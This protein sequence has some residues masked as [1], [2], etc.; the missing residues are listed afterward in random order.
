MFDLGWPH[1]SDSLVET[2]P[3][4][5]PSPGCPVRPGKGLLASA[6]AGGMGR[7]VNTAGGEGG[8]G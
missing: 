8:E 6:V 4:P 1:F 2:G 5:H 3:H 7:A